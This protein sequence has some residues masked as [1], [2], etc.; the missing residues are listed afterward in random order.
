MMTIRLPKK[1]KIS[2]LY[3]AITNAI[4]KRKDAPGAVNKTVFDKLMT[5]TIAF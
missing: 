2:K 4:S 5:L 3:I 1:L